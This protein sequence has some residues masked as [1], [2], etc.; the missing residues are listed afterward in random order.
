M[1]NIEG[2]AC[3]VLAAFVV[4]TAVEVNGMIKCF[5]SNPVEFCSWVG[6][7]CLHRY[8]FQISDEERRY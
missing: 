3:P 8:Q 2:L 7:I 5:A 6:L 4:A 1:C